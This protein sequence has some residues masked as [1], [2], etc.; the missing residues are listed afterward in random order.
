M[1]KLM[2]WLHAKLRWLPK[3][4]GGKQFMVGNVPVKLWTIVGLAIFV[5]IILVY[6]YGFV[7]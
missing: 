7:V 5:V 1:D 6:H 2:A 3:L 4:G